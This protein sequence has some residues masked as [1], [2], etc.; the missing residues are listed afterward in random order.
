MTRFVAAVAASAILIVSGCAEVLLVD[1]AAM[2]KALPSHKTRW[3]E[4]NRL[5]FAYPA[6]DVYAILVQGVERNGRKIVEQDA[7]SGSVVVAYPLVIRRNDWSAS[8]KITCAASGSGTTVTVLHDGRDAV[9]RV[10]A[11]GDEVLADVG[12]A[13]RRQARTL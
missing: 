10:H 12:G 5:E 7:A 9:E 8:L 1:A 2:A 4:A 11:I 13:L 6:A 3:I